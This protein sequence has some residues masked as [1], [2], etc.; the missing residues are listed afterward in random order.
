MSLDLPCSLHLDG[1]SSL[2]HHKFYVTKL[3]IY[4]FIGLHAPILLG[5]QYVFY[6]NWTFQTMS[7]DLP[8]YPFSPLQ[9]LY[10][11]GAILTTV[12]VF[13]TGNVKSYFQPGYQLL[14]LFYLLSSLIIF[15][16]LLSLLL[17][18]ISF[19]SELCIWF[20]SK[21]IN[22]CCRTIFHH[23]FRYSPNYSQICIYPSFL[24]FS[25]RLLIFTY[26]SSF[27]FS[28]GNQ[29]KILKKLNPLIFSVYLLLLALKF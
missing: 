7:I 11:S 16:N 15:L 19:H 6:P 10:G 14:L 12:L 17:Y 28:V 29:N 8:Y 5:Y 4:Y 3:A 24:L 9:I 13:I 23:L 18:L 27:R 25:G 21:I 22:Y 2:P 1:K 26:S 20:I